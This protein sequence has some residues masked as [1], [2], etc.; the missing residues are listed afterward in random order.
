MKPSIALQNIGNPALTSS[1]GRSL[2]LA[3]TGGEGGGLMH[4]P[5]VFRE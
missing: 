5:R 2:T 4:L 1:G 3:G